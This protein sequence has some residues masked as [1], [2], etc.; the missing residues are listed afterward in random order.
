MKKI[1][2]ILLIVVMIGCLSISSSVV[3][4]EVV[5]YSTGNQYEESKEVIVKS[6][7]DNSDL[8]I[9]RMEIKSEEDFVEYM[10]GVGKEIKNIVSKDT[11][12][13]DDKEVLKKTF[14][15]LADFVFYDKEI[16]GYKFKDLSLTSKKEV[17][18]YYNDVDKKIEKVY[19]NYKKVIEAN[20]KKTYNDLKEKA[21]KML[22]EYKEQL[23]A[24]TYSTCKKESKSIF[25]KINKFFNDLFKK[26]S[27]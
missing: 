25:T 11:I 16:K 17:L 19:P 12:T 15:D 13:K 22:E 27:D 18:K 8:D 1:I 14:I 5:N 26:V 10:K 20:S 21:S 7:F 3:G 24:E 9:N 6:I 2:I 23:K 4:T